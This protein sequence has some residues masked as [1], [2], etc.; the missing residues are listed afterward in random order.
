MEHAKAFSRDPDPQPLLRLKLRPDLQPRE[1]PPYEGRPAQLRVPHERG[2]EWGGGGGGGD[3][4][5][6]GVAVVGGEVAPGRAGIV[7]LM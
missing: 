2:R 4:T 5:V 1:V 6:Q 3:G 7:R